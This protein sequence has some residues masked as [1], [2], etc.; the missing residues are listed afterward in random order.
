MIP[1]IIHLCWFSGDKYPILIN[2]CIDSWKRVLPDYEI[3]IWTY[4][5]ALSTDIPFVKQALNVKKWAFAADVIR[6]QALYEY[7]GLYMDSDVF[8]RRRFDEFLDNKVVFFFEHYPKM[9]ET[10]AKQIINS[11]GERIAEGNIQGLGIQAAFFAAEAGNSFI[12]Q[13]IDHYASRSFILEDGTLNKVVSPMI[14]ALEAEKIGLKYIDEKQ[15][16]GDI[17]I[18][19]SKYVAGNRHLVNSKSFAAHLCNHSWHDK[20]AF[21]HFRRYIKSLLGW[22]FQGKSRIPI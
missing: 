11:K 4:E 6:L 1:K 14:F 18:Y 5:M 8:L 7:G 17:T 9:F 15:I 19:P 2:K 12:K 13:I 16:I 3:K 21:K 10:E 20:S 22:I